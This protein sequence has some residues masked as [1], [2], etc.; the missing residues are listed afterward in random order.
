MK[1]PKTNESFRKSLDVDDFVAESQLIIQDYK[2][3]LCSGIYMNP[4]V[5]L[6]GHVFCKNCILKYI[7]K[8]EKLCPISGWKLEEGNMSSLV[9]INEILG[10]QSVQCKNKT[11]DCKW[12]GKLAELDVHMSTQC[13]KQIV[14]CPHDGCSVHLLREDI[15]QHSRDCSFRIVICQDCHVKIPHTEIN[16][17]QS[18]CPRSKIHCPKKCEQMIER[19]DVDHHIAIECRNSE[20][21]CPYNDYGCHTKL[22]K[23]EL[24][25]HMSLNMNMHNLQIMVWLKDFQKTIIENTF[26]MKGNI[27]SL[28]GKIKNLEESISNLQIESKIENSSKAND[29]ACHK[30]VRFKKMNKNTISSG[31]CS[32]SDENTT[33]NNQIK[34]TNKKRNRAEESNK[35]NRIEI[36]DYSEDEQEKKITSETSSHSSI[37]SVKSSGVEGARKK[38]H[39]FDIQNISRGIEVLNTRATCLPHHKNEHRFVFANVIL[40]DKDTEWRI[41]INAVSSWMAL[42][43]CIKDQ[44]ISNKYRFVS[45]SVNFNHSFFGISINGYLWNAN[46]ITENNFFII[47]FPMITKGDIIMFKYLPDLKELYY[48]IPNKLTGRLTNVFS[49]KGG[50]ITPCIIFLNPGDEVLL[51][52]L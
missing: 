29:S 17:H 20:I 43:M 46:N 8:K 30:E 26:S 33:Q 6:C 21:E 23:K 49:P 48:K 5:D 24:N 38:E 37:Y 27:A 16:S 44:V 31:Q 11:S 18:D 25:D 51:E 41:I 32:L 52:T 42:G 4:V 36:I 34:Y 3:P 40:N 14:N 35:P 45:N 2:C 50:F 15:E 19:K 39:I 10:K 9:I 22:I 1:S 28:E 13:L 47:N 12:I 7:E